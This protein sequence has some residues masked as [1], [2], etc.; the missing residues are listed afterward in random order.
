[1]LLDSREPMIL[2]QKNERK[3]FVVA[4][5]HV[6]GGRKRLISCASRSSAS[7]SV[8]VVTIVIDRVCETIR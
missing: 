5:K 2:P 4:Q 7:A 1:M 6:V 8:R 3:A